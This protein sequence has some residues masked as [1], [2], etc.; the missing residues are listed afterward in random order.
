MQVARAHTA[1]AVPCAAAA[2]SLL[3]G[4]GIGMSKPVTTK[5]VGAHTDQG[6]S[7]WAQ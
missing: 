1:R 2:G 6:S 5:G 4:P 3:A 7:N